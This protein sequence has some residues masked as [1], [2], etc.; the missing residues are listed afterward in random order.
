MGY[1]YYT[2][3]FVAVAVWLG[4]AT[5]AR[6]ANA[7]AFTT[8]ASACL[9]TYAAAVSRTLAGCRPPSCPTS[10]APRPR[11]RGQAQGISSYPESCSYLE[12]PSDTASVGH[13]SLGCSSMFGGSSFRV[14]MDHALVGSKDISI[15]INNGCEEVA[16]GVL[17]PDEGKG[18]DL[19]PAPNRRHDHHR[20]D[21]HH[22]QQLPE[23]L[24]GLCTCSNQGGCL[25]SNK[26][27]WSD[28]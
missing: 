1:V 19:P 14:E 9:A 23:L 8:L 5:A 3:V 24:G 2:T 27:P 10:R 15:T 25:K 22:L 26:G 11:P 17:R 28:P 13:R 20:L 18:V 7:A 16:D 12:L 21:L 6:I 4:L